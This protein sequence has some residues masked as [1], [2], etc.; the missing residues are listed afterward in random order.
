MQRRDVLGDGIGI[1]GKAVLEIGV[2]RNVGRGR[3]LLVMRQHLVA[4][5]RAVGIA[6]RMGVAGAGGGQRLEAEALKIARAA[7]VPRIGNDEA[8]ALVRNSRKVLRLSAVDGRA[9]GMENSRRM[10]MMNACH[11]RPRGGTAHFRDE[12]MTQGDNGSGIKL[13]MDGMLV[14]CVDLD[15]LEQRSAPRVM[16]PESWVFCDTGADDEITAQGKHRGVARAEAA[17]ARAARHRRDRHVA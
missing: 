14:D 17:A 16:R 13:G 1:V 2:E 11:G 9:D 3:E 15:A 8:A 12:R 6:H 5:L 4:R 7:D 10:E